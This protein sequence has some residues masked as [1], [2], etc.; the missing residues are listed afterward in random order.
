M[1]D[2]WEHKVDVYAPTGTTADAPYERTVEGLECTLEPLRGG[3]R[4]RQ[5]QM[6][7]RAGRAYLMSCG[8]DVQL[9]E[10]FR[11]YWPE[12]ALTFELQFEADD[13]NREESG[14][15]VPAYQT[16][17]LFECQVPHIP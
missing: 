15:L 17:K 1:T 10:H 11:I 8:P 6:G 7:N 9:A 4:E 13:T 16:A 3:Y 2:V 14:S 5:E 12:K